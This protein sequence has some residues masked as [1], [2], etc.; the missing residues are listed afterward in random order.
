MHNGEICKSAQQGEKGD[1][2]AFLSYPKAAAP[3]SVHITQDKTET[4]CSCNKQ[5]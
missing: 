2:S 5:L 4:K 1:L 3:T